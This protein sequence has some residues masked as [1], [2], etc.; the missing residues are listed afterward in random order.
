[1]RE[2]GPEAQRLHL[3]VAEEAIR[4]GLSPLFLGPFARAQAR[5]GGAYA[6]SLEEAVA[7][8]KARVRPGDL[9]YLKASRAVGLERILDLWKD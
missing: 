6:E 8:L 4:L 1:M 2:L 3:E 9:V 5:L 7:W